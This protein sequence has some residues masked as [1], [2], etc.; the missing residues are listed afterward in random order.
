MHGN[1]DDVHGI[2]LDK[3]DDSSN[4][5]TSQAAR[6][7]PCRRAYNT[8]MTVNTGCTDQIGGGRLSDNTA[9]CR[10][11]VGSRISAAY[12]PQGRCRTPRYLTAPVLT[13]ALPLPP[14]PPDR[15]FNVAPLGLPPFFTPSPGFLTAP[16]DFDSWLDRED[17]Y[18][19][20]KKSRQRNCHPTS[21]DAWRVLSAVASHQE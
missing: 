7:L 12:L 14:L 17:L 11:L 20:T 19:A 4:L 16:S 18:K 21:P 13:L 8:L 6:G 10:T 5:D 9:R 3:Q 1:A 15:V 2:G